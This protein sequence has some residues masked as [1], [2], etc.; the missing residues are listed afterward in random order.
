M[1]ELEL[2][3][4][5]QIEIEILKLQIAK[6]QD[7]C[8]KAR[9]ALCRPSQWSTSCPGFPQVARRGILEAQQALDYLE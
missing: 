1:T 2:I 6:I 7:A 5:Q 9:S 8:K 3:A 4:K